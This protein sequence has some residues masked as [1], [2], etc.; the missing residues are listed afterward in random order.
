MSIQ[1]AKTK[2]WIKLNL[3]SFGKALIA[4]CGPQMGI[5]E[6]FCAPRC[7]RK[8]SVLFRPEQ[9]VRYRHPDLDRF[10]EEKTMHFQNDA[11]VYVR[12]GQWGLNDV[13][14]E[15]KTFTVGIEI[16]EKLSDLETDT[17]C[18]FY[19]GWTDFYFFVV[20]ND[21]KDAALAKLHALN[22]SRFG[23]MTNDKDGFKVW[24][25]PQRQQVL[26]QNQYALALQA[27]FS[28]S[29][30]NAEVEIDWEGFADGTVD[31]DAYRRAVKGIHPEYAGAEDS[32]IK[33]I[34]AGVCDKSGN[35][36]TLAGGTTGAVE[37]SVDD[38]MRKARAAERKAAKEAR[39]KELAKDLS[40]VGNEE[41]RHRLVAQTNDTQSV[42]HVIRKAAKCNDSNTIAVTAEAVAAQ[43]GVSKSTVET[44]LR[45]LRSAGLIESTGAK[46]TP[47]IRVIN[48]VAS[49]GFAECLLFKSVKSPSERK[50]M[51]LVCQEC[52]HK[53]CPAH[54]AHPEI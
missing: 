35:N 17:K 41:I 40:E 7:K 25:V 13:P 54:P 33:L 48:D 39:E 45:N 11:V 6:Q 49:G 42:Y 43:V 19:L 3:S 38:D 53:D 46:K 15:L 9:N 29:T 47:S 37:R 30:G 18:M 4:A 50:R 23:L 22:D 24:V 26:P 1:H 2:N 36:P 10:G 8:D 51:T 12:P 16:K 52:S 21:L 32:L 31:V 20:T 34:D 14:S 28:E 27:M 44:S 5:D